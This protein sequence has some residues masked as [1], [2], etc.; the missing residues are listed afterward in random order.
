MWW[1]PPV[2]W[3]YEL[4]KWVEVEVADKDEE[5]WDGGCSGD[6]WSGWSWAAGDGWSGGWTDEGG[7]GWQESW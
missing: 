6:A 7:S 2:V 5:A 1:E 4:K 3:D